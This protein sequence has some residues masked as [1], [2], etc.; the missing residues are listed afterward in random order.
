[1]AADFPFQGAPV[2]S[3]V[4]N[5]AGLFLSKDVNAVRG[6]TETLI[7]RPVG[8]RLIALNVA[9]G[10]FR[11]RPGD[12]LP[13]VFQD[14]DVSVATDQVTLAAHGYQTG[15]GPIKLTA[16]QAALTG[17][18]SVTFLVTG[19][20]DTITRAAGDWLADGFAVGQTVTFSG[21]VSNNAAVTVTALT[22]TI[23]SVSETV[24]N[25]TNASGTVATSPG[26][27]PVGID[28]ADQLVY[29][30][31]VDA[32]TVT[33]HASRADAQAAANPIDIT[34]AAS[35]GNHTLGGMTNH[36]LDGP[37]AS[38]TDGY[39]SVVLN[40]DNAQRVQVFMAPDRLTVLG[41][42]AGDTLSYWFLP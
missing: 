25:E 10:V 16:A 32:N 38:Q 41:G 20:D 3:V 18:P 2:P 6:T 4:Q 21:T 8:Q 30:R 22:P 13:R 37:T 5:E 27:L 29:V 9:A 1:M 19:G 26:T 39:G 34:A 15:D 23:M 31:A 36:D 24:V 17:D 42:S 11:V 35:G 7:T 28:T 40:A 12:Y 33:F 14:A